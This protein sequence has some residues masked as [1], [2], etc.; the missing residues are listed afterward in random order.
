MNI[1]LFCEM[2]QIK[3]FLC[4][5]ATLALGAHLSYCAIMLSVLIETRNQEEALARTLA[6]LVGGAVEGVVREVIVCD[7][8]S[9]ERTHHVA[10]HAGC[11][12]LADARAAAG[13]RQ[14]RSEWLLLL[15][16]GARLMDG[17]I[18]AV[19]AHAGAATG[20]ARFTRSRQS[21]APFLERILARRRPLAEG[22]VITKRQAL[23]LARG[24]GSAS[25]IA[26]AVSARRLGAEIFAA[27]S[28][29][30][31]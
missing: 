14:A 23:S 24:D 7:A 26:K 1:F 18:E 8:A 4:C 15:E 10:E 27:P 6:S 29:K 2:E 19:V 22:L 31:S 3:N 30:K 11:A 16:P 20:A 17:W 13:A 5:T 25:A 28:A 9:C 12:Y 21:R